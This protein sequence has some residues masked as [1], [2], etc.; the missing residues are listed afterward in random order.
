MP[1]SHDAL[2]A[3]AI[4]VPVVLLGTALLALV[5]YLDERRPR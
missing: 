5:L 1:A 2:V 4:A 3:L